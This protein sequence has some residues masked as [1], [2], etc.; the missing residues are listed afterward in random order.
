MPQGTRRDRS[1]VT[2][3][4]VACALE[5][6]EGAGAT[7]QGELTTDAVGADRGAEPCG[8]AE[9]VIRYGERVDFGSGPFDFAADRTVRIRPLRREAL[10][11]AVEGVTALDHLDALIEVGGGRDLDREAEPVEELRSQI[12][13]LGIAAADEDEARGMA[14]ADAFAFDDVLAGRG[15]VE[16]EVD[17]M[18]LEEIDLVDVEVAAVGAGEE[19]GFVRFLTTGEGA[20]EVEGADD[21]VLGRAEWEIDDGD[22]DFGG[23]QFLAVSFPGEAV[24]AASSSRVGVAAVPASGDDGHRREERR[25]GA[26][27]RRLGGASVTEDEDATEGGVHRGQE[28]GALHLVLTDECGEGEG[29][30][31]LLNG[32]GGIRFDST[33]TGV[34][35]QYPDKIFCRCV[36]TPWTFGLIVALRSCLEWFLRFCAGTDQPGGVMATRESAFAGVS[37]SGDQVPMTWWD[38]VLAWR[39]SIQSSPKFQ[40]W[41]ASFPLVRPIALRRSRAMF[42]LAAGFVYT[43]TLTACVRVGL[44][45]FLAVRPRSREEIAA[46]IGVPMEETERLLRAAAALGL[47][48]GR[49]G[50]RFGC[51]PMGAPLIGNTGLTRMI[52]HNALLYRDLADPVEFFREASNSGAV[53]SHFPYTSVAHP[54][55]F[56]RGDVADYS[57]LMAETVLPLAEDILDRYSLAGRKVVLDVGGGEGAFLAEVAWRYHDL[58]LKLFDLPAVIEGAKTRLAR[59]GLVGRVE[60]SGGNFHQDPLP[61]GADVIT[62]VRILLDHD[63]ASVLRLLHKVKQVLQPGGVLLIVEPFSGVRGAETVGDVYFGLYLRAMGRGRARRADELQAL[64]RQAGFG[65]SQV[66]KT[67]YPVYAGLISATH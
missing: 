9:D 6:G 20:F 45:D 62:L 12:A 22:R 25:E 67:R 60:L 47:V 5:C 66:H 18:I 7:Q 17:E 4:H 42:D 44:F 41:A 63:D 1:E 2:E 23:P 40:R 27:G 13:L 28:D 38:R 50:G 51:G 15:D 48:Q 49:S 58:Q 34:V 64:L 43:Q 19:A 33:C 56:G 11:V 53:N 26:D 59:L 29:D 57:S 46:H 10:G 21:A 65:R 35:S 36:L 30:S 24:G 8:G 61:V 55:K 37:V 32:S 3:V 52:K 16:E 39:D 31:H 14:D 54:E